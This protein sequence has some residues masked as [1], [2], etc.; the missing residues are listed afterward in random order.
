MLE[1]LSHAIPYSRNEIYTKNVASIHFQPST[2]RKFDETVSAWIRN[3]VQCL[4]NDMNRN[5][6]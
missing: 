5:M 2:E 6:A 4:N 1:H 3:K